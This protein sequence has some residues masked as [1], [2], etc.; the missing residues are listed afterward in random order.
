MKIM[1]NYSIFCTPEQTRKA[2]ELGAP[3]HRLN[4]LALSDYVNMLKI[5]DTEAYIIPTA[6]EMVAWLEEQECIGCIGIYTTIESC[7][8]WVFFVYDK[9]CNDLIEDPYVYQTR[10]E[11]TYEAIDATLKYL[12]QRREGGKE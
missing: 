8:Y 6:E 4:G 12:Q 3:L 9:E 2:L 7:K 5:S 1:G 11:A 10:R